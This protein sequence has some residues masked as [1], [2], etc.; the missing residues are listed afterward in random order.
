MLEIMNFFRTGADE[1]ERVCAEPAAGF[2]GKRLSRLLPPGRSEGAQGRKA[3]AEG[4][5]LALREGED[6]EFQ[7]Y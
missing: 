4:V 2:F 7:R 5:R 6:G 3:K 1:A